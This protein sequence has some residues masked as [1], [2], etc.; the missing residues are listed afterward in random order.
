MQALAGAWKVVTALPQHGAVPSDNL[1]L[2]A[3]CQ[4]LMDLTAELKKDDAGNGP[5]MKARPK[6]GP[7]ETQDTPSAQ[8]PAKKQFVAE[9]VASTGIAQRAED[10]SP[11]SAWA[12][13]HLRQL[14]PS[15][16][17]WIESHE[18]DP[19]ISST[20]LIEG[21]LCLKDEY[22]RSGK[23]DPNHEDADEGGKA[24]LEQAARCMLEAMIKLSSLRQW[25]GNERGILCQGVGEVLKRGLLPPDDPLLTELRSATAKL[26][27][28]LS[29]L[30]N[31]PVDAAIGNLNSIAVLLRHDAISTAK[32][33]LDALHSTC[34]RLMKSAMGSKKARKKYAL[35][36][37]WRAINP[38]LQ[39]GVMRSSDQALVAFGKWLMD[40]TMAAI[41]EA[42]SAEDFE[43]CEGGLQ[44]LQ[45]HHVAGGAAWHQRFY[46]ARSALKKKRQQPARAYDAAKLTQQIQKIGGSH[47]DV[48]RQLQALNQNLS[49]EGLATRIPLTTLVVALQ[50]LLPWIGETDFARPIAGLLQKLTLAAATMAAPDPGEVGRTL[51]GLV[52]V[53]SALREA[54]YSNE[55]QK[56]IRASIGRLPGEQLRKWITDHLMPPVGDSAKHYAA[57]WDALAAQ[58]KID[59]HATAPKSR[60]VSK[61]MAHWLLQAL[62]GHCAELMETTV[63]LERVCLGIERLLEQGL[64]DGTSEVLRSAGVELLKAI[65]AHPRPGSTY[66]WDVPALASAWKLVTALLQHGAVPTNDPNLHAAC[67][68]LMGLTADLKKD[69]NAQA[70]GQSRAGLKALL[71]HKVVDTGNP[72]WDQEFREADRAL[73]AATSQEIERVVSGPKRQHPQDPDEEPTEG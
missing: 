47:H 62:P 13:Q 3:A 73:Q 57:G 29:R 24:A 30:P 60:A 69:W 32:R 28:Q 23:E 53:A 33:D 41:Q 58:D 42:W 45:D 36:Q 40:R 16:R 35:V 56:F 48:G 65:Q 8:R 66:R 22:K 68:R 20:Q 2:L 54:G 72:A 43:A 38:L 71:E 4:R 34:S 11:T 50:G 46:E 25:T 15:L 55:A 51:D 14:A 64:F 27:Q 31:L 59:R 44:A 61:H 39:R 37:G 70:V 26:I 9:N 21:F 17:K 19:A 49:E 5:A 1:D 10:P 52:Q 67:R 12:P 6:A 63:E 7:Q 18:K